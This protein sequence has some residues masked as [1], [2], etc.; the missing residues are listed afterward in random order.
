[1]IDVFML[2]REKFR[3][4]LLGREYY[5][6]VEALEF[7]AKYH[8][9]LRKD[10]V[11]PAIMHQVSIAS[12]T[13]TLPGLKDPESTLI[14]AIL[15]DILEDYNLPISDLEKR[16]ESRIVEAVILLTKK[17]QGKK[18]ETAN[19]YADMSANSIA[20][21]VKGADRIHNQQTCSEVFTPQKQL[22]YI[23]ECENYL[24][25]MLKE[26]GNN[27]PEQELA[28]ENIKHALKGQIELL[29]SAIDAKIQLEHILQNADSSQ[30]N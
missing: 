9:G 2:R 28:Y 3:S 15:H 7:A 27:F 25:P 23:A 20:S 29:R 17:Y 10:G 6:A 30:R 16:F 13:K 19:Y 24:L 4:W 14:A 5:K 26:A 1:M 21:I 12:Y 18:K 11:T 8:T 22:E